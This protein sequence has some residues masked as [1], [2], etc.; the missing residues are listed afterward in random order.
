[1]EK[2]NLGNCN[3]PNW[4]NQHCNNNDILEVLSSSIHMPYIHYCQSTSVWCG[5]ASFLM[6][7][8][9]LEKWYVPKNEDEKKWVKELKRMRWWIPLFEII[10]MIDYHN[11]Q[12]EASYGRSM[13]DFNEEDPLVKNY[14]K[15]I[16]YM[17]KKGTLKYKEKINITIP[18]IIWEIRKW[19]YVLINWTVG[20]V[21]HMRLC[22]WFDWNELL[23]ADPLCNTIIKFDN[24]DFEENCNPPYWKWFISLYK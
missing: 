3:K 8:S 1:M 13:T 2:I 6:A 10:K 21:P 22:F 5:V 12:M 18:M 20:D 9:W 11:I 23:I 14:I 7:L 19:R 15:S 16:W 4:I 24:N 17:T